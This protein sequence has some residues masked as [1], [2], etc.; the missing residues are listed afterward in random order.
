MTL[1][2]LVRK[3]LLVDLRLRNQDFERFLRSRIIDYLY[4]LAA[5]DQPLLII[6]MAHLVEDP[7]MKWGFGWEGD[8]GYRVDSA[9]DYDVS[10]LERELKVSQ[11]A[12]WWHLTSRYFTD[13]PDRVAVVR[14]VKDNICGYMACM[15]VAT[16]PG[17]AWTDPLIGPWLAAR[18]RA[19]E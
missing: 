4:V 12:D 2:E 7:L 11:N 17:F 10:R 16:A 8:V 14:D 9:R 19:Q 1:H 13:S 6:D 5:D 15:S 18:A 3:A